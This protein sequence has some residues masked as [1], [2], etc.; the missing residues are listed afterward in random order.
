LAGGVVGDVES[1]VERLRGG[2]AVADRVLLG[3][4]HRMVPLPPAVWHSHVRG[5]ADLSF[6]TEAHHRIRNY[7][8]MELPRVG[9]P[10][11]PEH[12]SRELSLAPKIVEHVLE[13]LERHM[14]FLHRDEQGAVTWAYPVTVDRTPHQMHFSTGEQVNAA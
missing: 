8:V 4:G 6:M 9:E 12:I 3:V 1:I 13:E 11:S 2:I 10:L 7:V 5:D 14:T